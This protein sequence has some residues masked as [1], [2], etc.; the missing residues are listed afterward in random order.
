M[1]LVGGDAK[2]YATKSLSTVWE[3]PSVHDLAKESSMET[4]AEDQTKK[5][6]SHL[7]VSGNIPLLLTGHGIFYE[8]KEGKSSSQIT[9]SAR[10]I[11]F[12]KAPTAA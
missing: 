6:L 2:T 10:L 8:G 4:K 11:V 3:Y 5:P 12:P 9:H 7:V 1:Q